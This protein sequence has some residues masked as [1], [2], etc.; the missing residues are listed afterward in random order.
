[1][2]VC[3]GM[4]W[5]VLVCIG[6]YRCVL[7]PSPWNSIP[8]NLPSFVGL[9][10]L[11]DLVVSRVAILG[12]IS[13][14]SQWSQWLMDADGESFQTS[15]IGVFV[16]LLT[17]Q[18]TWSILIQEWTLRL[19]FTIFFHL[20]ITLKLCPGRHLED[21]LLGRRPWFSATSSTYDQLLMVD[22]HENMHQLYTISRYKI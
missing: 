18:S 19:F 22:D 8:R 17:M 2:L 1:M 7:V 21:R 15:K 12:C 3:I 20:I 14:D 11:G 9:A 6:V 16:T 10:Q 4:Y 13:R 5:Y